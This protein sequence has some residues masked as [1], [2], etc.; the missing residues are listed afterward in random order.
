MLKLISMPEEK[1]E[2]INKN[3]ES[4]H[5]RTDF[6]FL[7]THRGLRDKKLHLL[8]GMPGGGKST[9]R[10]SMIYD[11]LINNPLKKV[12]LWLSE[13]SQED[14]EVDLA[15]SPEMLKIYHKIIFFSEQDNHMA[16]SNRNNGINLFKEL[17]FKSECDLLILDNI[18]TSRL[19]GSSFQENEEFSDQIKNIV[20]EHGAPVFIMAHTASHIKQG[21]K[22]I[23]DM[24]DIR[25]SRKLV[26][27]AEFMYILQSF[28]VKK[29]IHT[30]V[31]V[32]KHR[33]IKSVRERLFIYEYDPNGGLYKRDFELPWDV[34]KK[35]YQEQNSLA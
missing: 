22:G 26:N 18:T 23:I 19:Y 7:D 20:A 5:F 9:L 32:V 11:F 24:N 28:H 34:F 33:G 35:L 14:F 8:I 12:M 16:L 29:Q 15:K 21:Y 2:R 30:T 13:E 31:R 17:V 3:Q 27:L 25:G 1:A 4:R 10:N 6:E